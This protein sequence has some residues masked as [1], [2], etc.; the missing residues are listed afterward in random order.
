MKK[1]IVVLALLLSACGSGEKLVTLH[2]VDRDTIEAMSSVNTVGYATWQIS[3]PYDICDI[4][5]LDKNQYESMNQYNYV[6][7]HEIRHCFE[8]DFH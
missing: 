5:V 8:G 1:I 7:G 4:Y 6:L 3:E 2:V